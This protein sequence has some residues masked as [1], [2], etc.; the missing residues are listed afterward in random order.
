MPSKQEFNEMLEIQRKAYTDSTTLLFTTLNKRMDDMATE[1]HA[2]KHELKLMSDCNTK[3]NQENQD[4]KSKVVELSNLLAEKQ[5]TV[6]LQCD[7][8]DEL[9]D[10][11]RSN[12]IRI[13]GIDD[14]RHESRENL[15][16][17]VERLLKDRLKIEN[18]AIE[19]VH[20]LPNKDQTKPR[21]II[22]RLSSQSTRNEIIKNTWRLKSTPIFIGED[23]CENTRKARQDQHAQWKAAREA[24]K[25]AY[26]NKKKLIIK[27][28]IE[29]RVSDEP[30]VTG[31]S[32]QRSHSGAE[33]ATTPTL[34]SSTAVASL[35]NMFTPSS[36]GA[37][38]N[39][40]VNNQ[41]KSVKEKRS[42]RSQKEEK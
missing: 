34:P 19:N 18:V 10:Y 8:I 17:K 7:R 37:S 36:G 41:D 13:S 15:Q 6:E 27:N 23:L 16:V 30:S 2:L 26:F 22:A 20:R 14:D 3:I 21:T 32:P 42:L 40:A 31:T 29:K 28:R 9:E 25:I 1:F 33:A 12:N 24:G 11:S 4:L 5:R 39:E 38:T 35:V